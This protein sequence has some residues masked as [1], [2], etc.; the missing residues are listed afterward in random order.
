MLIQLDKKKE[1][2]IILEKFMKSNSQPL[3]NTIKS[4]NEIKNNN[5][6][7]KYFDSNEPASKIKIL[8]KN[9]NKIK[10]LMIHI[11]KFNHK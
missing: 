11:N 3:T 7:N 8:K 6:N 5:N 2:K 9:Q 1:T 4:K 10:A